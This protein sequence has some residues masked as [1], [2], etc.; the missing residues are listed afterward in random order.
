MRYAHSINDWYQNVVRTWATY[1]RA[2]SEAVAPK[3]LQRC[4]E[5]VFRSYKGDAS[6]LSDICRSTIECYSIAQ[7]RAVVEIVFSNAIVRKIK[8]RFSP[9]RKNEAEG[10]YRDFQVKLNFSE[11]ENTPFEGFVFELQINHHEI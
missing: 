6:C 11:L 8:N 4:L 9:T 7:L 3:S 10:G 2:E 1:C 5:K